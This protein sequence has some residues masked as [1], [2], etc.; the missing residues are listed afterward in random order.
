MQ[1]RNEGTGE[2]AQADPSPMSPEREIDSQILVVED[3]LD[4]VVELGE[5]LDLKKMKYVATNEPNH[6][7]EVVTHNESIK[8]LIVDAYMSRMSGYS[9]IASIN[10][11]MPSR[12]KLRLII[13]TGHPSE[14]DYENAAR[15]GVSVFEKPLDLD[16]LERVLRDG[17]RD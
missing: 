12:R 5:W 9:L 11:Q 10:T 13:V 3:E 2:Q 4:T 8:L 1:N 16:A 6:A 15:L 17:L 7:I 14:E